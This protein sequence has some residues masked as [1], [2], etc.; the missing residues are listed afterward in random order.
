MQ[1]KIEFWGCP[2]NFREFYNKKMEETKNYV[3]F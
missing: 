1:T 3:E 2:F